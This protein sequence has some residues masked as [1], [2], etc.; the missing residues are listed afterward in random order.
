MAPRSA[1]E[2]IAA[3]ARL[4]GE[5]VGR[6]GNHVRLFRITVTSSDGKKCSVILKAHPAKFYPSNLSTVADELRVARDQVGE[7][8][9]DWSHD[10]LVDHL[11]QFSAEVLDSPAALRL[12]LVRDE[13]DGELTTPLFT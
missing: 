1:S 12:F 13:G 10:Q 4:S 5:Q 3:L 9:D 7:V 8:L 11:G 6:R 2:L